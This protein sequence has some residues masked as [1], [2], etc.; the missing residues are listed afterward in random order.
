M[1]E[2]VCEHNVPLTQ[3]CPDCI[4]GEPRQA[5]VPAIKLIS[6]RL[7]YT[8][9]DV[10]KLADAVDRATSYAEQLKQDQGSHEDVR[11]QLRLAEAELKKSR[12]FEVDDD[13]LAKLQERYQKKMEQLKNEGNELWKYFAD[14]LLDMKQLAGWV[15]QAEDER[16][17]F[18]I[19]NA[20]HLAGLRKFGRHLPPCESP[21]TPCTC[22]Y[23][24]SMISGLTDKEKKD[25]GV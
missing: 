17:Q 5:V 21:K 14:V 12:Y 22:G 3:E 15:R 19:E 16:D 7:N 23:I 13:A 8:L 1:N 11:Q 4:Q 20:R 9:Q 18:R 25:G 24:E 2:R 6:D 10:E